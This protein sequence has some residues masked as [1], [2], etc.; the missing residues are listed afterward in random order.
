MLFLFVASFSFQSCCSSVHLF[1]KKKYKSENTDIKN[2]KLEH[3]QKNHH[4]L[5]I[6]ASITKLCTALLQSRTAIAASGSALRHSRAMCTI[7][8]D[9]ETMKMKHK[10]SNFDRKILVW[11]K[12][13]KTVDEVPEVVK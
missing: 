8:K 7:L 11:S 3:L 2:K 5:Y 6:M 10:P 1:K 13:Y 12:K 9:G 4:L